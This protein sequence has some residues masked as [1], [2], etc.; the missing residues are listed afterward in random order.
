MASAYVAPSVTEVPEGNNPHEEIVHTPGFS[1]PVNGSKGA[2]S[3]TKVPHVELLSKD[4]ELKIQDM[5]DEERK[6]WVKTY[7]NVRK[8]QETQ[9]KCLETMNSVEAQRQAKDE[10]APGLKDKCSWSWTLHLKAAK[11][12][13][14]SLQKEA[15]EIIALNEQISKKNAEKGRDAYFGQVRP[16]P[17]IKPILSR[18]T[19][20]EVIEENPSMFCELL[21]PFFFARELQKYREDFYC[22]NCQDASPDK[23]L[24][25]ELGKLNSE[26]GKYSQIQEA[27][28]HEDAQR[29]EYNKRLDEW[30][31]LN[32]E[33]ERT[34]EW[35]EAKAA[36]IKTTGWDFE[37]THGEYKEFASI[38]VPD[39]G[40]RLDLTD[41]LL[42][43]PETEKI[44]ETTEVEMED[45]HM[46][47]KS[48]YTSETLPPAIRKGLEM[49]GGQ[50]GPLQT[51]VCSVKDFPSTK[52]LLNREI[53]RHSSDLIH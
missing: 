50:G 22:S 13:F 14:D 36:W 19:D 46:E 31:R 8:C 6:F 37:E 33:D 45:P 32:E 39:Q 27:R 40:E 3:S 11:Q 12:E 5:D 29:T 15:N 44:N 24:I 18:P 51:W 52:L 23:G 10:S 30:I 49:M 53:K 28:K 35:E 9:S 26:I 43:P 47:Y 25:R 7:G 20:Y 42:E 38:Y 17:Y 4:D 48:Q 2:I 41:E 16:W 1:A 21:K 34:D